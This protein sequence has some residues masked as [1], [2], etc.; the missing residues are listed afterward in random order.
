VTVGRV[1]ARALTL[2]VSAILLGQV[3]YAVPTTS[4]SSPSAAP[5]ASAQ[6]AP[7]ATPAAAPSEAPPATPVPSAAPTPTA[8]PGVVAAPGLKA[9]ATEVVA[10]RTESSQTFDNHDGTRTTQF[11]AAP[12]FY[13]PAGSTAWQPIA[14]G[15]ASGSAK[16]ALTGLV[17]SVTSD[18]APA[19]VSLFDAGAADFLSVASS[20]ARV[21]FALPA[22]LAKAAAGV[23]P[24]VTDGHADYPGILAGGAGLR[25]FAGP[26]GSKSFIVLQ[27]APKVSSWTFRLDAPGLTPVLRAG[28]YIDLID[29]T[30]AVQGWIP[31]PYAVDSAVDAARGGGVTYTGVALSLGRDVDGTPTVTIT[32]DPAMLAKATYPLYVDPSVQLRSTSD[33]A[34]AHTASASAYAGHNYG[35]YQRPDAPNCY[36]MW[37]GTDPSGTSGTS[38]DFIRFDLSSVPTNAVVDS[39]FVSMYPYHQYYSAPTVERTWVTRVTG[40]WT[41]AGIT[42]SNSTGILN[43]TNLT[44]ID[45]VEGQYSTS[46]SSSTF[47]A[48]VQGWVTT[49][50]SNY[51]LREWEQSY[52]ATY[53]KRQYSSE[54]GGSN[55][56]TLDVTYHI[57]D[58]TPPSAPS[59]P[60][61]A[62]ASDTGSSSTDNL[63]SA[64]TPTFTGTAEAGAT[65]TL[66]DGGAAVGTGTAAGGAWS[67]ATSALAQGAHAITAKATDAAGNTGA[68]SGALTVTVDTTPPAAPST[69][70]L[71]SA[72]DTGTSSTD[73]VTSATTP[74]FTGTAEAGATVTLYDGASPAGTATAAGGAWSIA[75]S[76]LTQGAHSMTA[77]ATDAAGNTGAASGALTV[78]VDTTPPSVSSFTGPATPTGAT[79]LAYALAFSEPV[80]G[81]AASDFTVAGTATGWAVSSVTGSGSGPYTVT[82]AGGGPG[83]VTL[84]VAAGAVTDTAGNAGP[85]AAAPSPPVTV[86]LPSP[87]VVAQ[88]GSGVFQA[89]PNGTV[90]FR[91]SAAVGIGLTATVAGDTS[92]LIAVGYSSSTLAGTWSADPALPAAISTAP[93]G[94]TLLPGDG[95]AGGTI[96]VVAQGA[97]GTSSL[98]RTVVLSPDGAAPAITISG[99]A[100][101]AQS[102]T[103]VTVA[104]TVAETGSGLF[105]QSVQRQRRVPNADGSC[106]GLDWIPDGSPNSGASPVT[107]S[108]LLAGYCYTWVVTAVDNVGNI[109]ESTTAPIAIDTAAPVVAFARPAVGQVTGEGASGTPVTWTATDPGSV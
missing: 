18:R 53:W 27:S 45:A 12:V 11:Y 76:A 83:T 41:E 68:A 40:S 85:A 71:A 29:A 94:L 7:P 108:A 44:F 28:G 24:T 2:V 97:G 91:P 84:T 106:L 96:D 79:S 62:A 93:Y 30:G 9:G 20:T 87:D 10:S 70:D 31:Q 51:G 78:T 64:T 89:A 67:I 22:A 19:T 86:E 88:S 39:A 43:N 32:A 99:F 104:W 17:P 5:D 49:Q 48:M 55:R 26:T 14:P 36:E 15:F 34:D 57:L 81:L 50:S 21:G 58:T 74:T 66:Y 6:A 46:A 103:S 109:A 4:A 82:L 73:N 37:L 69:P 92:R 60:D 105:S 95:P 13:K 100:S 107:Q 75:T 16:D 63:T 1:H 98:A 72:S 61:L 101:P 3:A 80:T 8:D 65:V 47:N 38:Y 35:A 54:Q 23:K 77:K 56:P 42:W 25:V 52:G 90:Y 33:V 59:T 102:S